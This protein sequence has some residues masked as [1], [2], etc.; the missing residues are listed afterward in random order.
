MSNPTPIASVYLSQLYNY[1]HRMQPN[2]HHVHHVHHV[3]PQIST[4]MLRFIAASVLCP[5]EI[6][7]Y[8][9]CMMKSTSVMLKPT[10]V[11]GEI[12][13]FLGKIT[14]GDNWLN[15]EIK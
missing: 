9:G 15:I 3:H 6:T 4:R 2:V 10:I 13:C 14:L 5:S 8:L 1:S 7:L 11:H 12:Q